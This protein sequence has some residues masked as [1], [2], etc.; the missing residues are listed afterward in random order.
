MGP[1]QT[2]VRTICFKVYF[3]KGAKMSRKT[4]GDSSYLSATL[5]E[6]LPIL[7]REEGSDRLPGG[8][9]A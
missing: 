1:P 3:L 7:R 8:E 4:G 5:Q 2:E 6:G 9:Q